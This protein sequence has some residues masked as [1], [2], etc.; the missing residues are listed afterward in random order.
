MVAL[1]ID[2]FKQVNDGHGHAAGDAALQAVAR[3][4]QSLL[5]TG[6]TF[7][8][9]GGEEFVVLLPSTDLGAAVKLA[10]RLRASIA[11]IEL[12]ACDQVL[13]I[14]ASFG[15]AVTADPS[16]TLTELL[17]AADALLYVAKRNGRNRVEPVLA[18]EPFLQAAE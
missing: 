4:C 7:A 16:T 18:F 11:A 10:E 8:R 1:D 6:D 15:C 14:T 5:R 12:Q 3:T 13:T 9:L 2:H 17:T